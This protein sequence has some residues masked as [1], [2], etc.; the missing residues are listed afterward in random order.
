VAVR[1]RG[2]SGNA[3]GNAGGNTG[4]NTQGIGATVRV[5]P[6]AGGEAGGGA[7]S[8][9][10]VPAQAKELVAGGQYLSDSAAQVAFAVG[11]ADSVRIEVT[12]PGGRRSVVT[13]GVNRLYEIHAPEAQA[14]MALDARP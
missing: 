14:P 13:G 8:V 3:G 6:L 5:R 4:G 1:L 12:W 11:E 2:P 9:S 10:E 7:G